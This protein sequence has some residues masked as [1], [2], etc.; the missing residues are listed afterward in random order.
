MDA[1][2][3]QDLRNIGASLAPKQPDEALPPMTERPTLIDVMMLRMHRPKFGLPIAA[4]AHGQQCASLAMKA[5]CD[6]ETILGCLLHDI[7]LVVTRPDH[8]WWGAQL[9]EPYVSERVSWAIRYHQAL[10]YYADPDVGYEYPEMYVKMW[11]ANYKPPEYIHAAYVEARNHKWYMAAR[12]I[13]MYDDYSFDR[14]APINLTPFADIIGRHFR[15]PKEG[16]G[17]DSSPTAHM[18]RTIIDPT[19]PL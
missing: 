18:W 2:Q 19:K 14:A 1:E 4:A 8:G 3:V 10:R 7:G 9:V 5:G 11:G 12:H 17:N 15:Q 6:E 13:T 16:L